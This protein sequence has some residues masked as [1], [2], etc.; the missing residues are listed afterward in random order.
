MDFGD[1]L[2]AKRIEP[3]AGKSIILN[4]FSSRS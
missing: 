2:L 1:L 3:G 4:F